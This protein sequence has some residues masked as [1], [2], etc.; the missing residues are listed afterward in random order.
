MFIAIY[1]FAVKKVIDYA[2]FDYPKAANASDLINNGLQAKLHVGHQAEG[3][4]EPPSFWDPIG[5]KK[6]D[7]G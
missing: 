4:V 2:I 5:P 7:P 1:W 6:I 3:P